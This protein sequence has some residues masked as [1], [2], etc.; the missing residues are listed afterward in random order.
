MTTDET[1]TLKQL[2]ISIKEFIDARDW[3]KYHN[4]KDLAISISLESSELLEIFQWLDKEEIEYQLK[5]SN[6]IEKIM[7]ELSDVM[8]YCISLSN[9]LDIDLSKAIQHK[10]QTNVSKYPIDKSK[11]IYRK[12]YETE[13]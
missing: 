5:N 3:N 1:T 6:L 10:I 13:N 8:I 11:G 2:R 9:A 7:E 4:P 12:P